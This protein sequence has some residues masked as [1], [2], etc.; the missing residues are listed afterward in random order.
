M[1]SGALRDVPIVAAERLTRVF[2]G[3]RGGAPVEAL[4]GVSFD[5]G[6]NELLGVVGTNGAGKTTLLDILATTVAP[7]GGTARVGGADI[8]ERPCDARARTGYVPA[9]RSALY[10]RLTVGGNLKFFAALY[11]LHGAAAEARIAESLRDCGAGAVQRVRADRVSDGM[12]A[13]AA[14]ARAMLH[15]PR[16]LLL[17]EPDRSI[18]PVH[19]PVL[20]QVIRRFVNRP[21]RA[22][23]VVSHGLD[24]LLDVADR[25]LVLRAGRVAD[26]LDV[27]QGARDRGR[28]VRALAGGVPA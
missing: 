8:R 25:V 27:R 21:G 9:G 12:A 11:G 19:R 14:L 6:A 26:L 5:V 28:V 16:V 15:D 22:A 10:P 13:R 3:A 24:D 4:A 23:I 1:D 2:A 17:D 7:S 18:D 20:L